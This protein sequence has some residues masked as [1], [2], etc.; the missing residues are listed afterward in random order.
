MRNRNGS[1]IFILITG[2]TLS[3][4]TVRYVADVEQFEAYSIFGPYGHR[5]QDRQY[6]ATGREPQLP[7]SAARVSVIQ[8]KR[9]FSA[10]FPRFSIHPFAM[11]VS[12]KHLLGSSIQSQPP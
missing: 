1:R 9:L 11:H 8:S 2:V 6:L 5:A 7:T 4:R 10:H 3:R 12:D